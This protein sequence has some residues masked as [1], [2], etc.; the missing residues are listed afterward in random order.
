LQKI[1]AFQGSAL[2]LTQKAKEGYSVLLAALGADQR[3]GLRIASSHNAICVFDK[4]AAIALD[5]FY[6]HAFP[7]LAGIL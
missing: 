4:F 5:L 3:A 6:C 2:D 7:T 1:L